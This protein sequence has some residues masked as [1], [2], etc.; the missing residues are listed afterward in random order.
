MAA[1]INA[2]YRAIAADADEKR[3]PP[4]QTGEPQ[5]GE[6]QTGESQIAAKKKPGKAGQTTKV[7]VKNSVSDRAAEPQRRQIRVSLLAD[8]NP[9][10]RSHVTA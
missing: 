7:H 6:S 3:V 2:R 9:F 10:H 8:H 4:A 1:E 5:T